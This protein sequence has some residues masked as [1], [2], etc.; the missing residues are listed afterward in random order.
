MSR[1]ARAGALTGVGASRSMSDERDAAGGN[2]PHAAADGRFRVR[3][4][5]PVRTREAA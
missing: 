2:R 1:C 4:L 5:P 3:A